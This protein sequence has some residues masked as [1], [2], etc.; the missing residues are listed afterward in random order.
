MLDSYWSDSCGAYTFDAKIDLLSCP[1]DTC[2]AATIIPFVTD[3]DR[4][5]RNNY[6]PCSADY[7]AYF[8][9]DTKDAVY[10]FTVP[11]NGRKYL[12]TADLDSDYG[13]ELSLWNGCPSSASQEA[14]DSGWD[15]VYIYSLLNNMFATTYYVLVDGYSSSGGCN[16]YDFNARI[17]DVTCAIS[18]SPG[19]N[20]YNG[21]TYACVNN[22][23]GSCGGASY[24]AFFKFTGNAGYDYNFKI[25]GYL[26]GRPDYT[27]SPII[28]LFKDGS[29]EVEI[30]CSA[31][32]GKETE[33]TPSMIGTL[34][35]GA[36]YYIVVDGGSAGA[37]V[38]GYKLTSSITVK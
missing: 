13:N 27:Y 25:E 37:T 24:D 1:N 6:C 33:L 38:G 9:Y 26:V 30:A 4:H 7:Y 32:S 16:Y 29:P 31:A 34:T 28:T 21:Y 17:S 3:V 22:Y 35:T 2:A 15:K 36:T 10:K 5:Y 14:R 19:T 20:V 11:Q 8:G 12:F 18:G 23:S